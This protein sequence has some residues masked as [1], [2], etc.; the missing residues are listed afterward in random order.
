[1]FARQWTAAV[2]TFAWI[3]IL[4]SLVANRGTAEEVA[5][6]D[7]IALDHFEK[8]VRP[9]LI[10]RCQKCHT[11][12]KAKGGLRLDSAEA[13]RRGGESGAVIVAGKPEDSPLIRAVR[14]QDGLKMP[15]NGKLSDSQ[16]ADLVT[17]VKD[18]ALWPDGVAD[19]ARVATKAGGLRHEPAKPN[20]GELS[21]SL[22]LWLR[23]DDLA[24]ADG[25]SVFVWPDHSGHGRDFSATKGVRSDGVGGGQRR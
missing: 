7:R 19:A 3:A 8:R 5:A 14:H 11:G 4:F 13:V 18:G 23:A 12:D 10:E 25:D 6:K 2:R 17:W 15:P 20:E 21:Q 24:L 16:I 9:L 1:M 22:Q